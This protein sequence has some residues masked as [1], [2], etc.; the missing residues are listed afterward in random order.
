[1]VGGVAVTV[2]VT[3]TTDGDKAVLVVL[4]DKSE[5]LVLEASTEELELLAV[6]VDEVVVRLPKYGVLEAVVNDKELVELARV[7]SVVGKL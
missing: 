1:M 3:V 7:C 5:V 2:T 4:L 6:T